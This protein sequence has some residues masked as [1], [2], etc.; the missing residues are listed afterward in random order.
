MVAGTPT[1]YEFDDETGVFTF[2]YR[3]TRADGEGRFPAGSATDL[4]VPERHYPH[5]YDVAVEGA[6]ARK[7][8]RQRLRLRGSDG[9][10]EVSVRIEPRGAAE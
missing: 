4:F 10:D 1:A 6:T 5:G 8:G 3:T 7:A 2:T 9:S